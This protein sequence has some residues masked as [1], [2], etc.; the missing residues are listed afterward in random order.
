MA[1]GGGGGGDV[2]RLA[3]VGL[4][5]LSP[6]S[7]LRRLDPAQGQGERRRRRRWPPPAGRCGRRPGCAAG[8]ART[9]ARSATRRRGGPRWC[10]TG[11]CRPT[12]GSFAPN[13]EV[14]EAE[15]LT[16]GRGP[17]P[18]RLPPRR[19]GRR[20][21]PGHLGLTP[22]RPAWFADPSPPV[23]LPSTQ[24]HRTVT[25]PSYRSPPYPNRE[26]DRHVNATARRSLLG[27]AVA[28]SLLMAACGSDSNSS[29]DTTAAAAT[30]DATTAAGAA[31]TAGERPPPRAAAR[32]PLEA[33]RHAQRLGRHLPAGLLR[34]A[35]RR[36]QGGRAGRD[37]Q[38][39]RRRL[40]QGPPGPRRPGR[41]LRRLRRR[42]Q[43]GGPAQ[44][45]GRRRPLL[46]DRARA[47]SR[48]R[49]NLDG[50]DK[51]Q[52]SPGHDRQDLPAPDQELE[53][54]GHRRRQPGRQAARPG[55]HRGRPLRRLGHDR[56]LHQV[57][58]RRRRAGGD[59]TWKLKSGSTVEWPADTQ[60]GNGNA[61][62]AQIVKRHARAP[63]ATSTSPTPRPP[64][65]S[66]PSVKNKAGKFVEPTLEATS[67][68]GDGIEVKP[69]LTFFTGWADGDDGLPDHRP[70]LDHRLH[71]T[72]PT[73]P[74][75]RRSKAYLRY[76]LDRR[77]GR[78]RPRSTSPR[79]PRAC[80]S[81]AIAQLDQAGQIPS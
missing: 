77:P 32:G 53:R 36:L 73:R 11:R 52:L 18:A 31:T 21:L 72:R 65:C 2:W 61:G 33:Q 27:G 24:R 67:A 5:V 48:C 74:R 80:R 57:P 49:Y 79:C 75:A 13:D 42:H 8:W 45:Q 47:R 19:R 69:D 76:M 10:A 39:R 1:T 63:S 51:L 60:A 6:P 54:P 7:P 12:T 17:R 55:H 38:L 35:D 30:D 26:G 37:H 40:G 58:G 4:E 34:G 81:K 28:L 25:R 14:D 44:V 46:P 9:W 23:H 70:D 41:R 78:W 71:R 59:G 15:W 3:S 22:R 66:T 56:E 68:A 62:V 29:S 64:A 20:P 43:A 16:A 50:V